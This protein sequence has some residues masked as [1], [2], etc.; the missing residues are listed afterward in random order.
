VGKRADPVARL[1]AC[2]ARY[3]ELAQSLADIGFIAVGSVTQRFTHCNKPGCRCGADPPRLH[4]PYYQWTTKVAG[5]TVTR[6]L[7]E[8]EAALYEEQIANGRQLRHL[9][10]EMRKVADEARKLI[11]AVEQPQTQ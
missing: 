8:R 2:E 3:H 6:R 7:N 4:G 10:A 11:L 1:A 9:I 5:R